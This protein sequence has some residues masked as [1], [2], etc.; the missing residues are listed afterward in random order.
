MGQR[1]FWTKVTVFAE[2]WQGILGLA[3][4]WDVHS[5]GNEERPCGLELGTLKS[6]HGAESDGV[7]LPGSYTVS[8]GR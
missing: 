7:R 5:R 6:S 3:M 4:G 1:P 2:V 8:L